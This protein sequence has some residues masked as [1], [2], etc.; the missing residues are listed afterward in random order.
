MAILPDNPS[1]VTFREALNAINGLFY[2][3]RRG[4]SGGKLKLVK[5]VLKLDRYAVTGW[6]D[7][8]SAGGQHEAEVL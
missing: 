6:P 7:S 5:Q 2:C 3:H 1:G 4:T 8:R